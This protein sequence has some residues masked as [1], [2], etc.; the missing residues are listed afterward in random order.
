MIDIPLPPFPDEFVPGYCGRI[1]LFNG[2]RK[3]Q[4]WQKPNFIHFEGESL[5]KEKFLKILSNE[6]GIPYDVIIRQ[7]T[8]AP[9]LCAF[10]KSATTKQFGDGPRQFG[11]RV[12]GA[13]SASRRFCCE[14]TKEDLAFWKVSYWRR[15]HQLPGVSHCPKHQV[16]LCVSYDSNAFNYQPHSQNAFSFEKPQSSQACTLERRLVEIWQG[17]LDF[18]TTIHYRHAASVYR[19]LRSQFRGDLSIAEKLDELGCP[20]WLKEHFGSASVMSNVGGLSEPLNAE[21]YVLAFAAMSDDTDR[22]LNLLTSAP[23]VKTHFAMKAK[24]GNTVKKAMEAF[25][26]GLP[27]SEAM[28]L[29]GKLHADNFESEMRKLALCSARQT[30]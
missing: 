25:G 23:V 4:N 27:Y 16:P 1:T 7:H 8:L 2:P 19:D 3:N 24:L 17:L 5:T 6:V 18:G 26:A 29:A 12:F 20:R 9:A 13:V 30:H 11:R 28:A 22:V 21:Y 15:I 14:C 10:S